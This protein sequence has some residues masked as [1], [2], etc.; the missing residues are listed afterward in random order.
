MELSAKNLGNLPATVTLSAYDRSK[1]RPGIAHLSVGNFHRAHQAVYVDRVLALPNQEGWGI[2]GIGLLDTPAEQA[3]AEALQAQDGLYTLTECPPDKPDVVRVIKSLVEYVHAPADRVAVIRR[4]A[5]PA[6]RLVTMTIT[7]GGYYMDEAGHFMQAHPDMM[8][9]LARETPHSA[10]GVL[11]EALRLRRQAGVAPFAVLSC[12]NVPH[13]GQVARKALLGWAEQR[14]TELASWISQ[15]V[16]FPS[17]MVD[18]ITPAVREADIRRLDDA[19]GIEDRAPVYCEDFIQWV[20]E[21]DF[22]QGRPAWDQV[23]VLFTKNVAPYEQVKLRMLNASHSMMALP[24]VL[25]GYRVVSDAMQDPAV[26]SLLEQFLGLDAEPLLQAPPGMALPEYGALLLSRFRNKAI[27]DQ[28]VR[29]ASDSASKLPVFIRPTA[30]GVVAH[31]H[32]GRRISFLLACFCAYLAGRDEKGAVYDVLEPH[33]TDEDKKLAFDADPT[34][35]LEMTVFSGWDLEKSDTFV[36]QFVEMRQ[37]LKAQ[38][39]RKTLETVV[40]A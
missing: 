13:N 25:M 33:L 8:E 19:S 29:I 34:K 1:V 39:V 10:F 21:D 32:D 22:P 36:T 17:C 30:S 4:L 26:I 40:L 28:L 24:G 20:V 11:V 16:A 2:V 15:T 31:G 6:L 14:D 27:S 5:D 9:D 12:D 37:A 7:E 3:K 23:G 38:G 35:A 18:R